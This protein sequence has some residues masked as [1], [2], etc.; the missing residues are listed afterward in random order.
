MIKV[1]TV[2]FL[3]HAFALLLLAGFAYF[4]YLLITTSA[5]TQVAVLTAVV[6]VGT[7]VY[8]QNLASRREIESRQ[9]SKK[10]EAYEDIMRTIGGLMEASRDGVEINQINLLRK[11]SEIVPKLM[12]WAGP[13][14]LNAWKLM[15]TPSQ[16]PMASVAAAAALI[17]AL[18][19]EL[20][21][22]DDSALGS[23]GALSAI[24]KHDESG[25]IL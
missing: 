13:D 12:V 7:I 18:R 19:K 14:V 25:K 10:A 11:L 24:L 6:S 8:T 9:F 2:K 15:A 22:S 1:R 23:F 5:Q 16:E 17:T 20:G 4:S 21:H 3:G